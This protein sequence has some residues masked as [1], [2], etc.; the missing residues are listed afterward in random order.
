ML[1]YLSEFGDSN[2]EVWRRRASGGTV[3]DLM[4]KEKFKYSVYKRFSSE[5]VHKII[6]S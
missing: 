6:A 4:E 1:H 5:V 3:E 2:V